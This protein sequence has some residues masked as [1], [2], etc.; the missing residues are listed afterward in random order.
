MKSERTRARRVPA[1][2]GAACRGA[3]A[4]RARARGRPVAIVSEAGPRATVLSVSPA[5]ARAASIRAPRS[6]T[7]APCAARSS[8]A[9]RSPRSSAPRAR[10]LLDVALSASPRAEPVRAQRRRRRRGRRT[11]STRPG[12]ATSS[13]AKRRSRA[14]SSSARA[15]RDFPPW[16][17][18]RRRGRSRCS[19]RATLAARRQIGAT[20]VVAP[21][22]EASF[23]APLL[24]RSARARTTR[25]PSR[26]PASASTGSARSLALAPATRRDAARRRPRRRAR[27]AARRARARR[28]SRRRARCASKRVDRAEAPLDELEPL[29]LR[30]R[31]PALARS[32]RDSRCATSP[33]ATLEIE[34]E[35]AAPRRAVGATRC[36]CASPRRAPTRACGCAACGSRS[37][38]IRRARPSTPSASPP[39]GSPA[40]R[41]QLDLFRPAGPAPAALDALLAELELLCGEG[42]VGAPQIPDDH[43]PGA[44][45]MHSLRAHRAKRRLQRQPRAPDARARARSALHSPPRSSSTRGRPD[46]AAQ[47]RRERRR[48]PLRGS[49][50]HDR[51]LVVRRRIALPSTA[52]TSRPATASLVRLRHDRLRDAWHVDAVY[53]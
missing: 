31:R 22:D 42:R 10:R 30:D 16:Q 46:H 3:A 13:R 32:S 21:G 52:S 36:A 27:R 38:A 11:C 23:L 19:P 7:R 25:S 26:S 28:R 48:R 41:D 12:S 24:G 8:C 1:R 39:K 9:S 50:A 2:A 6:R 49:L 51:R 45:A 53:D 43:H 14:R 40:R 44:F 4:R 35:L 20:R 29:P 5:A 17:R 34:L 15:R 37:N 47:R 33:A 18:S